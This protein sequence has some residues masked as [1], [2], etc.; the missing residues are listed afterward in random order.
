MSAVIP[1]CTLKLCAC[2]QGV[3]WALKGP[4]EGSSKKSPEDRRQVAEQG[5]VPSLLPVHSLK[6]KSEVTSGQIH[7]EISEEW[8]RERGNCLKKYTSGHLTCLE[9]FLGEIF[10][11]E[12]TFILLP[13]RWR[14]WPGNPS[15]FEE[16]IKVQREAECASYFLLFGEL[17]CIVWC[18]TG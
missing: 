9:H 7:E 6:D 2:F 17:L 1:H 18:P 16:R 11:K 13:Q 10:G 4:V 5:A 15:A 14:K 12:Y 3:G 8:K